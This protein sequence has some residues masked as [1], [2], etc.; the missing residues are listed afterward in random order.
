[1]DICTYEVFVSLLYS[2]Q[3]FLSTQIL[4]PTTILRF[5]CRFFFTYSVLTTQ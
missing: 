3:L 4:I 5:L 2:L 1:M